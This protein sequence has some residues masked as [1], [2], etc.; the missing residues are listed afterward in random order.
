MVLGEISQIIYKIV[1]MNYTKPSLP[2]TEGGI[3]G[4][5]FSKLKPNR[6]S[7]FHSL[8]RKPS[9]LFYQ[10]HLKITCSITSEVKVWNKERVGKERDGLPQWYN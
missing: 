2:S 1:H 10:Y 8:I 3:S 9:R 4:N 7:F 6:L 5:E